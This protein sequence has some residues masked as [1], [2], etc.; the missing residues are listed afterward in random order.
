MK[1]KLSILRHREGILK[2]LELRLAGLFIIYG[3]YIKTPLARKCQMAKV[4]AGHGG[5]GTLLVAVHGGF[6]G[7]YVARSAGL[8]LDK[9]QHILVPADEI[10][11][12]A[13]VR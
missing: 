1:A 7:L 13:T 12:T 9:T 5:K 8:D 10:D 4:I 11:L 6:G 2:Q 3:H